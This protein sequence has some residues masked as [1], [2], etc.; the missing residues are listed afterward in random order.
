MLSNDEVKDKNI[1][2]IKKIKYDLINEH[3]ALHMA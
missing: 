1:S 2:Q 3:I